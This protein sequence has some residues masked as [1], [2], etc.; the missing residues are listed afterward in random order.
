MKNTLY[1]FMWSFPSPL[2]LFEQTQRKKTNNVTDFSQLP[3]NVQYCVP[4]KNFGIIQSDIDRIRTIFL[5][6]LLFLQ[7][8][9]PDEKVQ[10]C[11]SVLDN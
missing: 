6:V 5:Q 3:S 1:L 10:K 4:H 8:I 2:Y 7:C 11:C 9:I